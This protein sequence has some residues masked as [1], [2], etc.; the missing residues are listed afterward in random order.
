[1]I[2]YLNRC[3]QRWRDVY[4]PSSGG[5]SKVIK[6]KITHAARGAGAASVYLDGSDA[7]KNTLVKG[8]RPTNKLF[9]DSV[10]EEL[11]GQD[12]EN[13][14]HALNAKI[15]DPVSI[16]RIDQFKLNKTQKNGDKRKYNYSGY[17]HFTASDLPENSSDYVKNEVSRDRNPEKDVP[18]PRETI[19]SQTC[20][21][22][23]E[24]AK[25]KRLFNEEKKKSERLRS[26]NSKLQKE[27][28][29]LREKEERLRLKIENILNAANN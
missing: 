12:S 21:P 23:C 28:N 14:A 11:D 26:E 27:M 9:L 19:T 6:I 17:I 22:S 1:M 4:D 20:Q 18:K 16:F 5:E 7:E 2:K 3:K 29:D 13:I 25:Y 15:G 24:A 8:L 10:I